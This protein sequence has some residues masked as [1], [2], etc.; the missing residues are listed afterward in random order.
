ML[1]AIHRG[2][3]TVLYMLTYTV[4]IA[5]TYPDRNSETDK[6]ASRSEVGGLFSW[7]IHHGIDNNS[8]IELIRDHHGITHTVG[9]TVINYM[10]LIM[11]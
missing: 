7:R 9:S 6:S 10:S 2:Q 3:A 8:I 11:N 1:I 5:V 4:A